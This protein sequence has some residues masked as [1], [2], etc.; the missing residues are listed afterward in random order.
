VR[1][2]QVE[3]CVEEMRRLWNAPG[4]L[5]P[6]PT[7]PVV[8]AAFGTKMAEVAGRVGDGINTPALHPRLGELVAIARDARV[9]AGRDPGRF[10]VTVYSELHE[11]WFDGD[12]PARVELA[13]LGVD[14]LILY[15][16]QPF[17]T[18]RIGRAGRLLRE[19]SG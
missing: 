15:L 14:R 18:A 7:P 9:V 8:V 13:A 12:S 17:D 1:R 11:T 5:R 4:F 6:D 2:A 19:T 10:L 16:G 3:A